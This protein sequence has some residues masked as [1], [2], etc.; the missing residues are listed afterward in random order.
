MPNLRFVSIPLQDS[1]SRFNSCRDS[2]AGPL[3]GSAQTLTAM[4]CDFGKHGKKAW[5]SA[6]VR[7]LYS[8]VRR[9][10]CISQQLRADKS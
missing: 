9:S 10:L 8:Y 7:K 1:L 6:Y 3:S 2:L 4:G 5:N